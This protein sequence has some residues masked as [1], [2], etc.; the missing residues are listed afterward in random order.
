MQQFLILV[1][2]QFFEY[3]KVQTSKFLVIRVLWKLNYVF[4]LL[5][6]SKVE[7]SD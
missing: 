1:W 4:H 3:W 6:L 7:Y 5:Q 2:V